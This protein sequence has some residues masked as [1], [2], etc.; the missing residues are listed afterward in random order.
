VK[1]LDE[2]YNVPECKRGIL[3]GGS[4]TKR[5]I[6]QRVGRLLRELGR[7][8]GTSKEAVLYQLYAG[9]TKEEE[10]MKKRTKTISPDRTEWL[11]WSGTST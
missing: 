2:G 8:G 11:K 9:G 1:A 5:Q 3:S 7:L 4:S 6:I 10:Y